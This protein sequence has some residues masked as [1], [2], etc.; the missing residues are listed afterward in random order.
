MGPNSPADETEERPLDP[1]GKARLVEYPG[2]QQ[3]AE[4]FEILALLGK[5]IRR[6]L[7]DGLA[8]AH[9]ADTH[10]GNLGGAEDTVPKRTG[11]GDVRPG[12]KGKVAIRGGDVDAARPSLD[13]GSGGRRGAARR[14][15][16]EP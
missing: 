2:N 3:E 11:V 5:H 16:R 6:V 7:A 13:R 8:V 14:P 4:P 10:I 15:A 1:A 12:A 9:I